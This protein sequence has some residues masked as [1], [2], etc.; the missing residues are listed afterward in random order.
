MTREEGN[1]FRAA[2]VSIR[3]GKGGRSFLVPLRW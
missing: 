2:E 3:G 1:C